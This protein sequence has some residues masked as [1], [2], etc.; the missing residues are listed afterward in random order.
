MNNNKMMNLADSSGFQ[1]F[2]NLK[3]FFY[4]FAFTLNLEVNQLFSQIYF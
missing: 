1:E 3:T 2:E 4:L